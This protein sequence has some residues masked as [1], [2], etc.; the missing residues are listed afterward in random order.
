MSMLRRYDKVDLEDKQDAMERVRKE[1]ERIGLFS[2]KT[3]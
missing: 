2:V 1:Y 3:V